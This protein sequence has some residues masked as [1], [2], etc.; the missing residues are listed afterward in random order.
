MSLKIKIK[1]VNNIPV[2]TLIGQVV[3]TDVNTLSKK[4]ETLAKSDHAVV[5]I[6]LND[7]NYIDSH[8]LGVFVYTLKTMEANNKRLVFL[9]PQG[10][11]RDIFYETNLNKVLPVINNLEEL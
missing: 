11:I 7:A 6:D 2:V 10:L 4:L 3:G 5:V 8:G 1:N 9:N